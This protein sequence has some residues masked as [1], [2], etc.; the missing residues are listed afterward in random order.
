M[1][2]GIKDLPCHCCGSGPCCD[3]VSVPGP[4]TSECCRCSHTF[5][6]LLFQVSHL[7]IHGSDSCQERYGVKKSL[8]ESESWGLYSG[9][10][11]IFCSLVSFPSLTFTKECAEP[12]ATC[13]VKMPPY[14]QWS[15]YYWP[16][17]SFCIDSIWSIKT[18]SSRPSSCPGF[19]FSPIRWSQ[20]QGG[21]RKRQHGWI[22]SLS[23]L[24][25]V[26]LQ[27]MQWWFL[28]KSLKEEDVILT[29]PIWTHLLGVIAWNYF[30]FFF[31]SF[32]SCTYS[33]WKFSG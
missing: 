32:Y 13:S 17:K 27:S 18:L 7:T 10:F 3:A 21:K 28:Q 25:S 2:Q 22:S 4:G 29:F 20:L 5:S 6:L 33:F 1:A 14:F 31:F 16:L 9:S 12:M 24:Q 19:R 30:I 11:L 23:N 26:P 8:G 15:I